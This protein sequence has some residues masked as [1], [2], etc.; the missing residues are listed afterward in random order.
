MLPEERAA[1]AVRREANAGLHSSDRG[2]T[3]DVEGH[4]RRSSAF[5]RKLWPEYDALDTTLG[6]GSAS[7]KDKDGNAAASTNIGPAVARSKSRRSLLSPSPQQKQGGAGSRGDRDGCAAEGEA[8]SGERCRSPARA[9][10]REEEDEEEEEELLMESYSS[11]S[12]ADELMWRRG[13]RGRRTAVRPQRRRWRPH[14]TAGGRP[15]AF[16]QL[17]DGGG[18][19]PAFDQLLDVI[20]LDGGCC[21]PGSAV[22]TLDGADDG[23]V[24]S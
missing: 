6:A 20:S 18:V 2:G 24:R 1:T 10:A 21:G 15:P 22:A 13:R 9:G 4:L 16:D 17:L 8:P 5:L 14:T 7:R 12:S 19:G 3:A 23:I 11:S